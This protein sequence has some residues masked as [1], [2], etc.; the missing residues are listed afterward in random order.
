MRLYVATLVA[1]LPLAACSKKEPPPPAAPPPAPVTPADCE[2]LNAHIVDVTIQESV[3]EEHD[4]DDAGKQKLAD[5]LRA[6]MKDDPAGKKM[7]AGCEKEFSRQEI[8]CMMQAKG[9][10]AM[11]VCE[12]LK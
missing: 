11:D 3:A 8:D 12:G 2:K 5:E 4:L 6:Q 10:K 1:L 9:S 7:A